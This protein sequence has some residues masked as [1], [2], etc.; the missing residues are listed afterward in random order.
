MARWFHYA[1]LCFDP[2]SENHIRKIEQ[3]LLNHA[4]NATEFSPINLQRATAFSW[5]S[6][7]AFKPYDFHV[8]LF[9]EHYQQTGREVY[10]N[11]INL[12]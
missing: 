12:L 8:L 10:A 4:G 2:K 3:T 7:D 6:S 11:E 5:Y 9:H 1:D